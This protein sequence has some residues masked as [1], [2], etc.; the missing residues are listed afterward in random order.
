[1]LPAYLSYYL[2][3][4]GDAGPPGR[5]AWARGVAGGA[6]AALGAFLAIAAIGALAVAL[7]PAFRARV[8]HLELAG[9]LAVLALGALVLSGR[10]PSV[11]VAL[12]PSTRRGAAG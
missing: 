8:V 1:M 11:R 7:G 3:R 5:G 9:G 6:V 2:T 10:G 12:R 4:G